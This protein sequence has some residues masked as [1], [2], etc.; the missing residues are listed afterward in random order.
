MPDKQTPDEKT[1]DVLAGVHHVKLTVGGDTP[2][3]ITFR[4]PSARQQRLIAKGEFAGDLDGEIGALFYCA[5]RAGYTGTPDEF[6]ELLEGDDVMR[7]GKAV[8]ELSPLLHRIA[9]SQMGIDEPTG[10]D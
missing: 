1:L 3:E 7:C 5:Q 8:S 4:P 10:D 2:Q 6:D 9:M